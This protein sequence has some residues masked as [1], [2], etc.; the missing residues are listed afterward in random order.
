MNIY[1]RY[2]LEEEKN[3]SFFFSQFVLRRIYLLFFNVPYWL[4]VITAAGYN[5]VEEEEKR[6][7]IGTR[8]YA[9]YADSTFILYKYY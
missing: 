1:K 4:T 6:I 9:R 5:T 7:Q 3:Y 8:T 2:R